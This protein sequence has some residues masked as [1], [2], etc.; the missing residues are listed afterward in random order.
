MALVNGTSGSDILNGT[1][2]ADV[3][4]SFQGNDTALGGRGDD[5]ISGGKG[6]DIIRGGKGNDT[7]RGDRGNDVLYGDN[8]INTLDGG[9]GQDLFVLGNG[10]DTIT[11]FTLGTD[12]IGLSGI[13]FN[14]L[15]ITQAGTN[16]VISFNGRVLATLLNTN[17]SALTAAN[18]TTNL[19]PIT[20]VTPAPTPAPT[21]SPTPTP[22]PPPPL[23][24]TPSPAPSPAPTPTA[25]PG[26]TLNT[27]GNLGNLGTTPQAAT[28]NVSDTQANNYYRFTLPT[29]SQLNATLTGLSA[30]ADLYIGQ[31]VNGNGELDF[32]ELL[33]LSANPGTDAE[34]ISR[35]LPPGDYF[36]L[37][38]QYEGTTPYSLSVSATPTTIPTDNAGNTP[39]QA[40][41][42]T[43]PPSTQSFNDFVGLV[44]PVDLYR[45]DLTG[46]NDINIGLSGLSA[47][48]DLYLY[49]DRNGDGELQDDELVGSSENLAANPESIT[50]NALLPDTYYIAV[51]AIDDTNYSLGVTLTPDT[52]APQEIPAS[53]TS[54]YNEYFGYGLI[55][56]A[57]A[58]ARAAGQA[59][60]YPTVS[61]L[62]EAPNSNAGDLNLMNVP[63]VWAQ[64][65][66]GAG[67]IV[68]V[69]DTGVD[70]RHPDLAANVW[71]NTRE[72]P[73]N[74][75]DDDNNGFVD[76][77]NGYDF[78]DNDSDPA[79]VPSE[80][81]YG[82]GTHVAGTIAAVRNGLTTD[83]NGES[84]DTTG[85]AYNAKIMALR[86]LAGQ[87]GAGRF[88][89]PIASAIDYAVANGAQVINMSLGIPGSDLN[90]PAD[91]P[92]IRQAL[93]RARNAGVIVV[94][95]AAGNNRSNFPLGQVTKP[96]SPSRLSEQNL[97]L[98]I[99]ALDR[100]K[101]FASFSNPAGTNP[102]NFVSAP[103]V[104]VLSTTPINTYGVK[105]GTSM[106]SPN[107]AGVLAL[108]VEA[109]RRSNSTVT[110][111]QVTQFLTSTASNTG[112]TLAPTAYSDI[113]IARA[114]FAAVI[115]VL[116]GD[117]G[118]NLR[119]ARAFNLRGVQVPTG[120]TAVIT[121]NS[122][123]QTVTY[124][125]PN[126][127]LS[128]SFAYGINSDP[129][130]S[131]FDSTARV[132][133]T[134]V[135]DGQPLTGTANFE[136]IIGDDTTTDEQLLGN[137]GNDTLIG[138]RGD[139]ILTGGA[140]ADEFRYLSLEDSG[141][142]DP[143]GSGDRIL[144]FNPSADRIRLRFNASANTPV[145]A[146]NLAVNLAGTTATVR[147]TG[148]ADSTG[149]FPSRFV[150]N[151]E[152]LA[153]GT[154][155]QQITD[156]IV[157]G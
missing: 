121:P 41:T 65:I 101:R 17:S 61:P 66:T 131:S 38:Q 102:I 106:A 19:N 58:V 96:A 50:L 105:S 107:T 144:D 140:G 51:A 91:D 99:G 126:V 113:A 115:P 98:S 139:D 120:R 27:A 49:E 4:N 156:A 137:A 94:A 109:A 119:I 26:Q 59:N 118:T 74:G 29:A 44:D 153:A 135:D 5:R 25:Q 110:P 79:E 86:V 112:L 155:A 108:M 6:F 68:A 36:A 151:L 83:A 84:Y 76:D 40:R 145:A 63:A 130:S 39:N 35:I 146:G 127:S 103:G 24:P 134:T 9:D 104:D 21:P 22:P 14:Q 78:S 157:F 129:N 141:G 147:L 12:L 72:T 128:D 124:T 71:V 88:E 48:A 95:T 75:I 54:G 93:E 148:V 152:N 89:D 55:N 60:P 31:D 143:A 7:I 43:I 132:F 52:T 34:R 37:V 10:T 150:I 42:V 154:T 62:P 73:N 87:N 32:D 1:P 97:T 149:F 122:N 100:Q 20:A 46:Q 82:H 3:I 53:T 92:L 136:Y 80:R 23:P 28:G 47:D 133:V 90:Q 33:D 45:I 142:T 16:A 8:G 70:V 11:D 125:N 81:G 114:G 116:E 138:N 69:L 77:V 123:D 57:A 111:A 2:Q 85:V 15:N 18:F 117:Q 64:G 56:A 13:N 30:D 67:V